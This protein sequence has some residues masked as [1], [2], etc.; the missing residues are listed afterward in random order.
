M[1]PLVK[2]ALAVVSIF[3]FIGLWNDFFGPI[4]YLNSNANYTVSLGLA[5]FKSQYLTKWNLMMAATVISI[6]P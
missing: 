3:T 2:P 1:L 6:I 5:L 4:I